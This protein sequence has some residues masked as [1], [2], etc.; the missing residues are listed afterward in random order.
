[1]NSS[2]FLD[3]NRER[4]YKKD[5]YLKE[6]DDE[7]YLNSVNNISLESKEKNQYNNIKNNYTY[8]KSNNSSKEKDDY[9][10]I[11]SNNLNLKKDIF[12][13]KKRNPI[14]V[15]KT[16]LGTFSS[17]L[18][19]PYPLITDN[20]SKKKDN[21]S[22]NIKINNN[23]NTNRYKDYNYLNK[24]YVDTH[25]KTTRDSKL[26]KVS[27][28]SILKKHK[29]KYENRDY[30]KNHVF[31]EIK[32]SKNK[33][34]S[35]SQSN[36]YTKDYSLDELNISNFTNKY[37]INSEMNKEPNNRFY[38]QN[39]NTQNYYDL[40]S[41]IYIK[42]NLANKSNSESYFSINPI[43]YK[44]NNR[45]NK[46]EKAHHKYY[47]SKSIKKN[48]KDSSNEN[49]NNNINNNKYKGRY[50][51]YSS[52]FNKPNS[53]NSLHKEKNKPKDKYFYQNWNVTNMNLS[54]SV[55]KLI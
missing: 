27:T 8:Q 24:N 15:N 14:I 22:L 20:S 43:N 28:D 2:E 33:V 6:C 31:H 55:N 17:R 54:N 36:Y 40:N 29:N 18:S 41:S 39:S 4:F 42:K 53:K 23:V 35:N 46:N 51:A 21:I 50:L 19:R 13:I 44:N 7:E 11:K 3:T 16:N 25:L 9:F 10:D 47:E 32:I 34:I 45:N 37:S 52:A 1:M 26:K 48:L 30:N 12:K 49:N 38:N 5:D